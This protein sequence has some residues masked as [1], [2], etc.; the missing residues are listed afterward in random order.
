[1]TDATNTTGQST[2]SNPSSST[3]ELTDLLRGVAEGSVCVHRPCWHCG[4]D[5]MGQAVAARCPECG[6]PVGD[7]T[8]RPLLR[9]RGPR[10]ARAAVSALRSLWLALACVPLLF[11]AVF[12]GS[13][14][15]T[16]AGVPLLMFVLGGAF[17][18]LFLSALIKLTSRQVGASSRAPLVALWLVFAGG[19]AWLLAGLGVVGRGMP[20]VAHA[21]FS[22]AVSSASAW[23]VWSVT[24]AVNNLARQ[25][26]SRAHVRV[27]AR[28]A[29]ISRVWHVFL[30]W[31][32]VLLVSMLM[33][34]SGRGGTADPFI[35]LGVTWMMTIPVHGLWCLYAMAACIRLTRAAAAEARA[36]KEAVTEGSAG[37][38]SS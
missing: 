35:M 15:G 20:E 13:A 33:A 23:M 34:A 22:L 10:A 4:Y 11:L 26:P 28:L 1:M 31:P 5:L 37:S 24:T 36:A 7:S 30:V 25:L 27:A 3:D 29:W 18:I 14:L 2:G 21:V 38:Q 19:A 17:F 12:A 8:L 6:K 9:Q 32:L 16:Q